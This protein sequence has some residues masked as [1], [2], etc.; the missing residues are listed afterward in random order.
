M[1]GGGE[2]ENGGPCSD[3]EMAA[4]APQVAI[5]RIILAGHNETG[6]LVSVCVETGTQGA[7]SL[8]I[9]AD[10]LFGMIDMLMTALAS[11]DKRAGLA[12]KLPPRFMFPLHA[13]AVG[14]IDGRVLLTINQD[15]PGERN[16]LVA[17]PQYAAQIGQALIKQAGLSS[18]KTMVHDGLRLILPGRN[19]H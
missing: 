3:E 11:A 2:T 4:S 18:R 7:V 8:V 15:R 1:G 10:K 13:F 6:E 16:Y 12:G 17:E 19:G 9:E 14:E 5:E